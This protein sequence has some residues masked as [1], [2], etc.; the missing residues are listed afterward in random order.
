MT[1]SRSIVVAS[2]LVVLLAGCGLSGAQRDAISK[3][4]KASAALA[5]TSSAQLVEIRTDYIE[6]RIERQKLGQSEVSGDF[7]GPLTP[8]DI[9]GPIKAATVLKNYGDLLRSLVA[10]TQEQELKSAADKFINSVRGL[11]K[12]KRKISDE[13]LE[14]VGKLIVRIGGMWIEHQ[15]AKAIKEIVPVA[16][17][18]VA[19]IGELMAE[20]FDRT[21]GLIATAY[22]LEIKR[23]KADT[24]SLL[25]REKEISAARSLAVDARKL[26][27]DGE[28]RLTAV[29]PGLKTASTEM[30]KAHKRLVDLLISDE[31]SIDD[32]KAFGKS[33]E[34]LLGAVFVLGKT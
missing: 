25:L 19:K 3:F 33:V 28:R 2:V 6:M 24:I 9:R 31:L 34:D 12:E 10:D 14:A 13:Q 18:Q 7:D 30:V 5:E 27:F 15:K 29:L 21:A 11:D 23:L 17:E 20:D 1:T 8:K 32:I 26:S 16:H 4:S 22:D